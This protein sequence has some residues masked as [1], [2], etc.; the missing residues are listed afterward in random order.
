MHM[1]KIDS[2]FALLKCLALCQFTNEAHS[3]FDKIKLILYPLV[4]NSTIHLTL[5]LSPVTLRGLNN[6]HSAENGNEKPRCQDSLPC[7]HHE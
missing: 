4:R 2:N 1:V 3:F 7:R 6:G 5:I